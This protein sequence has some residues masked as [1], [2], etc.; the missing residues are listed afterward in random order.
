M[1]EIAVNNKNRNLSCNLSIGQTNLRSIDK[2]LSSLKQFPLSLLHPNIPRV[3]K[4]G[5]TALT[6]P[7]S[8]MARCGIHAVTLFFTCTDVREIL[9]CI[10]LAVVGVVVLFA[11]REKIVEW[12]VALI[13]LT[14]TMH[15]TCMLTLVKRMIMIVMAGI[16]WIQMN[17]DI[18]VL[19]V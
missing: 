9:V 11:T 3:T 1:K 6:A 14:W 4:T 15:M 2:H 16:R 19:I 12:L 5:V 13:T 18:R 10:L 8:R 17:I 7:M